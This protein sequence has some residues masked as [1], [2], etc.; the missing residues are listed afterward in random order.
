M[1]IYKVLQDIEAE[2]KILGPL[3]LRQFIFGLITAFLLYIC[4]I[5]IAKGAPYLLVIFLPPALLAG[6]FAYP[7]GRDQ[8]TEVW[9][10]A[11]LRFLFKPRRRM[12]DQSGVKEL[13]TITVPK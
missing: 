10:V 3:T 13:V 12:W 5:C 6:F 4:F 9:A 11:K 1:A 8:P 2:D 7:F